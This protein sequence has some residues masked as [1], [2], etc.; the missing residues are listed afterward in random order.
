MAQEIIVGFFVVM[1]LAT[2]VWGT[3]GDHHRHV[4]HSIVILALLTPAVSFDFA[5]WDAITSEV[6][7]FSVAYVLGHTLNLAFHYV[8]P[9]SNHAQSAEALVQCTFAVWATSLRYTIDP[10][11]WYRGDLGTALFCFATIWVTL[12]VLMTIYQSELTSYHSDHFDFLRNPVRGRS[13]A[14]ILTCAPPALGIALFVAL[15]NLWFLL[16]GT[17][18]WLV[19]RLG[20]APD[21]NEA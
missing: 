14:A 18:G 17:L 7:I 3:I 5:K 4:H 15:S 20:L 21:L 10:S 1:V 2:L 13:N 16:A 11:L 19:L 9:T 12:V 8:W 6:W